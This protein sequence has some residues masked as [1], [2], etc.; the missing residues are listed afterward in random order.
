MNLFIEIAAPFVCCAPL[1]VL[2]LFEL[3]AARIDQSEVDQ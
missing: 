2:A 3:W 1:F